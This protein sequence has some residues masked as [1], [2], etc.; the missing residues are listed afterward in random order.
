M[1]RLSIVKGDIVKAKT[2]A[3]VNAANTSLLGGGGVDGKGKWGKN[4]CIPFH[5]HR[6]L[7]FPCGSGGKDRSQRDPAFSGSG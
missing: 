5:Q 3:I 7:P 4:H 6:C 1:K 2:D